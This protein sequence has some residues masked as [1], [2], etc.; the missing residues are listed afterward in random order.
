MAA[1]TGAVFGD[2]AADTTKE[3]MEEG[4]KELG[5][6]AADVNGALMRTIG[7]RFVETLKQTPATTHNTFSNAPNFYES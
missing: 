7:D 3:C 2:P 5:L 4:V 6:G 1:V